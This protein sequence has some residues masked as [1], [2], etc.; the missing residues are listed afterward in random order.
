MTPG[1]SPSRADTGGR[2]APGRST[3]RRGLLAAATTVLALVAA[4]SG[5][6]PPQDAPSRLRPFDSYRVQGL[7]V[8][9]S[10][11]G[12]PDR[13]GPCGADY[14]AQ[15]SETVDRVYIRVRE[16]PHASPAG[17]VACPA[18][19]QVRTT[20]VTL[21]QPLGSRAVVDGAT[22]EIVL[23]PRPTTPTSP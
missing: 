1:R 17:E 5:G 23:Q 15:A 14:R 7:Q 9:V 16:Y 3:R 10:F 8:V 6:S 20:S 22:G 21:A 13:P 18:I 11:S 2:P 19:A 4:C 12:V